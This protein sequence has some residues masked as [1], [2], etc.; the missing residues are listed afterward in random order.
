MTQ[1]HSSTILGKKHVPNNIIKLHTTKTSLGQLPQ[2]IVL[3]GRKYQYFRVQ[4]VQVQGHFLK[5]W[6]T[7]WD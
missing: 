1:K 2:L 5:G 3:K 7:E 4:E 6:D